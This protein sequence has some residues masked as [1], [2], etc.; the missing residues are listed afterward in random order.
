MI[1]GT[2]KMPTRER[3]SQDLVVR[4]VGGQRPVDAG[5]DNR[6]GAQLLRLVDLQSGG[7]DRLAG[8]D[9]GQQAETVHRRDLLAVER[10]SRKLLY[11]GADAA[12]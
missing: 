10:V 11:L 6:A 4:L 5:A 2:V 7:A 3:P 12:S 9:R 8:R 1:F